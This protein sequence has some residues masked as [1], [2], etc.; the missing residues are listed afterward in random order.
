MFDLTQTSSFQIKK[1]CSEINKD[2]HF[3]FQESI[4]FE[5]P[6][7]A[8]TPSSS[9]LS[10]SDRELNALKQHPSSQHLRILLSSLNSGD[11]I[12]MRDLLARIC[13][14]QLIV[15]K[16]CYDDGKDGI[17]QLVPQVGLENFIS[18][19]MGIYEMIPDCIISM[20]VPPRSCPTQRED[21]SIYIVGIQ[22]EGNSIMIHKDRFN[23]CRVFVAPVEKFGSLI[24]YSNDKNFIRRIDIYLEK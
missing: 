14:P 22:F 6:G 12:A 16:Y 24:I 13:L 10:T 3:G 11:P 7:S 8:V 9:D 4:L 19:W 17:H 1:E 15:M 20:K 2:N 23:D 18:Y 5:D 21:D